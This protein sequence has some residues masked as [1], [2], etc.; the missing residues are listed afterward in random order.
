MLRACSGGGRP[1]DSTTGR[2][3]RRVSHGGHRVQAS[4]GP[5]GAISAFGFASHW[6]VKQQQEPVQQLQPRRSAEWTALV[7]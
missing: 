6:Q 3:F 1:K 5:L 4:S 7:V 2:R